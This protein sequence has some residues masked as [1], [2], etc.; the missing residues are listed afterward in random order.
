[1]LQPHP[2]TSG[3]NESERTPPIVAS[4]VPD[5]IF[6][7]GPNEGLI[8]GLIDAAHRIARGDLDD[9]LRLASVLIDYHEPKREA[10]DTRLADPRI[11]FAMSVFRRVIDGED[12]SLLAKIFEDDH[13]ANFPEWSASALL[14]L[15]RALC[16]VLPSPMLDRLAFVAADINF[17]HG[18]L[19]AKIAEDESDD[20]FAE[21]WRIAGRELYRASP[22]QFAEMVENMKR[23]AEAA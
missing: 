14:A 18:R 15:S 2:T 16:V 20:G 6:F 21:R 12:A 17:E 13:I 1:M 9:G 8:N 11:A 5:S 10:E 22:E 3:A 4:S 19:Q 23:L 7:S